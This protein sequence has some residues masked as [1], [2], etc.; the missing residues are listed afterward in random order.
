MALGNKLRLI[1]EPVILAQGR[2][3]N[4]DIL[5]LEQQPKINKAQ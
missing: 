2:R 3:I 5:G 4:K 1:F